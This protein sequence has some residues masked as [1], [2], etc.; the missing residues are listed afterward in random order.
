[1]TSFCRL[2]F[3]NHHST[4]LA[5]RMWV[6]FVFQTFCIAL[7]SFFVDFCQKKATLN[8]S[9]EQ[10]LNYGG[11]GFSIGHE[12]THAFDDHGRRYLSKSDQLIAGWWKFLL[13]SQIWSGGKSWGLVEQRHGNGIPH[14]SRMSGLSNQCLVKCLVNVLSM[15]DQINHNLNS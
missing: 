1:M 3:F 8:V 15:S 5:D 6:T 13:A 9:F 7:F 12:L 4:T 14:K 10:V 2:E 11:I